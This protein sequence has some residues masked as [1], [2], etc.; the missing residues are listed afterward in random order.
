MKVPSPHLNIVMILKEKLHHAIPLRSF[1]L[2][3]VYLKQKHVT[4]AKQNVHANQ[5]M[6]L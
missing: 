6:V 4:S 1:V 3:V 5:H 2:Y